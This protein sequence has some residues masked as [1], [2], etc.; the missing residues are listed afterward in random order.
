VREVKK[1]K[2][3][4]GTGNRTPVPWSTPERTNVEN[5]TLKCNAENANAENQGSA[6]LPPNPIA[7]C[8]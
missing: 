3:D 7:G 5:A 1:K 4:P 6:V 2:K 8:A